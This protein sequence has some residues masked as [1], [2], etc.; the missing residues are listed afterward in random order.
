M[1]SE[2]WEQ[3][4]WRLKAWLYML[5]E[6]NHKDDDQK[7]LQRGELLVPSIKDFNEK[8]RWRKGCVWMK[9]PT[10][11][12]T[13]EFWQWLRQQG[14]VTTRRTTRG[15]IIKILN[16]AEYQGMAADREIPT[17][18]AAAATEEPPR[19][20]RQ[21]P[22]IDNNETIQELNQQQH[23]A[24]I[25]NLEE[26]YGADIRIP[27]HRF[28]LPQVMDA[29]RIMEAR[30]EEG[31]TV[32]NQIGLIIHLCQQR[33]RWVGSEWQIRQEQREVR[34]RATRRRLAKRNRPLTQEQRVH[35]EQKLQEMKQS[36]S[37][38]FRWE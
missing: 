1:D 14:M 16:F 12:A 6:A 11:E 8:L 19:N 23:A 10:V 28:S 37:H 22:T 15:T 33:A 25:K 18:T 34:E 31:E 4:P 3:E 2:I 36:L 24:A 35:A 38:K 9:P 13:K 17:V 20:H 27:I 32:K 21:P 5:L 30:M 26:R 7:R 29:A